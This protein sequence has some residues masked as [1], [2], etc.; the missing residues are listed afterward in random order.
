MKPFASCLTYG[1]LVLWSQ[2]ALA[3]PDKGM[4]PPVSIPT[5]ALLKAGLTMD[6]SLILNLGPK[7]LLPAL[8]RVGGCSGSFVS[9]QGL[10]ITNHHCA[11]DAVASASTTAHNYL[12]NGFYA[13]DFQEEIPAKGLSLRITVGYED[14][15]TQVLEG[16]PDFS[17]P[18]ERQ[19]ALKNRI[20][21]LEGKAKG[22]DSTLTYEIAEMFPGKSYLLFQY[23][24]LLDVRLVYVPSRAI[25]EFGGE[26]DNWVWPRHTGDF[27]LVRA[28]HSPDGQARAYHTDN[29]P[30]EP[31]A[32][33]KIAEQPLQ[34]DDFVMI[35]G[36]PGRTFRNYPASYL[37]YQQEKLLPITRRNFNWLIHRLDSQSQIS[38]EE[39]L[40]WS[41]RIKSLANT[42]KNYSGKIQG[43]RR[44]PVMQSF[45]SQDDACRTI[46]NP[47]QL[48]A[49]HQLDSL[50]GLMNQEAE[51][52]LNWGHLANQSKTVGWLIRQA[53]FRSKL[54][55][56]ERHP[57]QDSLVQL[58][59]KNL[60]QWRK[61]N[62]PSWRPI[63]E[64][65]ILRYFLKQ[66][67]LLWPQDLDL[68]P[69]RW[70]ARWDQETSLPKDKG[71]NRQL[72]DYWLG[73]SRQIKEQQND[74]TARVNA[75]LPT[76]I[77][78]RLAHSAEEF[79]PD[80]NGTLRLT[81][82]HVRGYSPE[83]AVLH[84]PFT[85]LEGMFQKAASGHPDYQLDQG[86]AQYFG[87]S[88]SPVGSTPPKST[89]RNT[90]SKYQDMANPESRPEQR[91]GDLPD[92]TAVDASATLDKT[93]VS[94]KPKQ[95]PQD[96]SLAFLYN[97]D[98]TGGNSG[99]PV[100][101]ARGELVGVNFDRAFGATIN[102]YAWNADYSRSIGV[103][104]QFVL[105]NLRHQVADQR[106][107]KE[108]LP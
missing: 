39:S 83:N 33:L 81:Y 78:M 57:Q 96:I 15:S 82:G 6:P 89:A 69:D 93:I 17:S 41:S 104:I 42:A 76:F 30:Y 73:L 67:P 20:K 86:L 43:L 38:T 37:R 79:I 13:R 23:K 70:L 105:W 87:R 80:A 56:W 27:T 31:V 24:I 4:Y 68:S 108:L 58:E 34:E 52:H 100:I 54:V 22:M 60:D 61:Q 28:Y 103:D 53:E 71:V 3:V 36:Y 21:S 107:L 85:N 47:G 35:M 44:V 77:E 55:E 97:L 16:L 94:K 51:L 26:S 11:F 75:L 19:K 66:H 5:E 1:F 102:D 72:G 29:I 9:N 91:F 48:H 62:L 32:H 8:V 106:I 63:L 65:D 2:L 95:Q 49:L 84:L 45:K 46:A 98:T 88:M 101:N 74:W 25:G 12:E 10:I 40:L 14:I 92:I 99:S 7:G 18:V 59:T 90:D 50:Y 64:A